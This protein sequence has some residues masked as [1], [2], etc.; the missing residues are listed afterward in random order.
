M[1]I[2]ALVLMGIQEPYRRDH[3][4]VEDEVPLYVATTSIGHKQRNPW[5]MMIGPR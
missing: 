5:A 1:M 2:Q 3:L 4:A